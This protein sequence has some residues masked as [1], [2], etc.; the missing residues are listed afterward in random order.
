[1][2]VLAHAGHWLVNLAYALPFVLLLLWMCWTRIQ[3]KRGR[4][5]PERIA[6]EPSLDDILDAPP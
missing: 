6:E 1:M 5:P 3:E 2:T 4:R